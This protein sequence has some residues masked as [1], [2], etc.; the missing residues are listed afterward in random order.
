[1]WHPWGFFIATLAA[2]AIIVSIVD[3][4]VPSHYDMASNYITGIRLNSS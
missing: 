2:T 3:N 1:M 4:D